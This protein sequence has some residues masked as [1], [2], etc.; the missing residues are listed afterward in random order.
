MVSQ[1]FSGA[2]RKCLWGS[3]WAV[4]TRAGRVT[5]RCKILRAFAALVLH[6]SVYVRRRPLCREA[7]L[8][9][10][11]R[12]VELCRLALLAVICRPVVERGLD[13]LAV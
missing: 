5:K 9:V 6:V 2:R 4:A 3:G 10:V 12:A 8:A 7:L 11:R 1:Q 13:L